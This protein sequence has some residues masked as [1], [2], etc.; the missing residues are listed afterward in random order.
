[1]PTVGHLKRLLTNAT[2]V[3]T[4]FTPKYITQVN[5]EMTSQTEEAF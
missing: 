4:F 2:H 5:Q 3:Y 1:M